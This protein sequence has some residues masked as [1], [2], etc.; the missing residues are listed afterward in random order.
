M[1]ERLK[2]FER[3]NFV[4]RCSLI[5]LR[6]IWKVGFFHCLRSL[7]SF[8]PHCVC[9]CAHT[10]VDVTTIRNCV[11][12]KVNSNGYENDDFGNVIVTI[13]LFICCIKRNANVVHRR[14][15]QMEPFPCQKCVSNFRNLFVDN[16]Q[17]VS[18]SI[19]KPCRTTAKTSKNWLKRW[20]STF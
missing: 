2:V 17:I 19:H 3:A 14:V 7:A 15:L 18:K 10:A 9:V 13:T 1:N 5:G 8:F 20:A 16:K 4:L 12:N 11:F 6:S